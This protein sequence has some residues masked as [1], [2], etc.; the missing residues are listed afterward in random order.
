MDT[1]RIRDTSAQ[2][3]PLPRPRGC[4]ARAWLLAGG[5]V[6]LRV[7]AGDVV[8]AGQPLAVIDNP[9]LRSRL[10]Q[11]ESTLASLEGE[12]RRAALDAQLTRSDA[13]KLPDQARRRS[14]TPPR[15]ATWSASS[16]LPPRRVG[17]AGAPAADYFFCVRFH[18]SIVACRA[19]ATV[20][21]P[22]GASRLTTEPAPIVAPSPTLTGATSAVFE[23]MKAPSPIVVLDL[24][25]PS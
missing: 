8:E 14:T 9:E 18:P 7:V 24:F 25:T 20:S 12:A 17:G 5:T 11:E 13:Q 10:V 3:Q 16:A 6:A 23:P 4:L 2:D 15:S 1:S 22:A 19:R 21:L